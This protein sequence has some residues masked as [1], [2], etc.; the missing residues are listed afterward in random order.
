M[1]GYPCAFPQCNLAFGNEQHLT[2]HILLD[3]KYNG[4]PAHA[5]VLIVYMLLSLFIVVD[6][7]VYPCYLLDRAL[8]E[9][10]TLH[11]N[12]RAD[13]RGVALTAVHEFVDHK[14]IDISPK[15][16]SYEQLIAC[17]VPVCLFCLEND[18][19]TR[20]KMYSTC[21]TG[22]THNKRSHFGFP[23]PAQWS[24]NLKPH[25]LKRS[26]RRSTLLQGGPSSQAT[27]SQ[28]TEYT[29]Q[30]ASRRCG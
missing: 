16:V 21:L 18:N 7:Y 24:E 10:A 23:T 4:T 9:V 12:R 26:I 22:H 13:R 27:S 8:L 11:L 17:Q 5:Y 30:S 14:D 29:D 2:F 28:G 3:H 15:N 6:V 25:K 19:T 20:I 1:L